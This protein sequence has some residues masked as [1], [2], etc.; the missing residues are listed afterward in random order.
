MY[1]YRYFKYNIFAYPKKK[2]SIFGFYPNDSILFM[3]EVLGSGLPFLY[4]NLTPN[5]SSGSFNEFSGM[6]TCAVL[7]RSVQSLGFG[8]VHVP[9]P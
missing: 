7:C 1:D 9:F 6:G 2:Y 4:N 5:S 3:Y 8:L